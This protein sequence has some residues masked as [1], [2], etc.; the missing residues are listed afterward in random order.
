MLMWLA[1]TADYLI[2]LRLA[3]DRRHFVKHHLP[4]LL[5]LLVPFLRTL[6]LLRLVG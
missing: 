5:V 6:L 4:D 2:R 1:F 3:P